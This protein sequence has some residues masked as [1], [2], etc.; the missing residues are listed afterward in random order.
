M[1]TTAKTKDANALVTDLEAFGPHRVGDGPQR[2]SL[3]PPRD[4]FE[5]SLL[6]GLMR[7]ELAA[8]AARQSDLRRGFLCNSRLIMRRFLVEA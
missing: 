1:M 5:D 2:P 7:G 6:L 3:S 8:L 4:H